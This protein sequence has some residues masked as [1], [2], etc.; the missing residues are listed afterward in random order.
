M[1]G[2]P[3]IK[4]LATDK[5]ID[6][7]S[8]TYDVVNSGRG[9]LNVYFGCSGDTL[10]ATLQVTVKPLAPDAAGASTFSWPDFSDLNA[11]G[12]ADSTL[13]LVAP[14]DG[15]TGTFSCTT[16][17]AQRM[18]TVTQGAMCSQVRI[19]VTESAQAA[20]YTLVAE[21]L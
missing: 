17:G 6:G 12:T 10:T 1:S 5:G 19:T 20:T 14:N 21:L 3:I 9:K 18:L 11:D 15:D 2:G 8:H 7:T 13:P 16:S 4:K